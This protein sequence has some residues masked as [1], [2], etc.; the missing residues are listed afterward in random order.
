MIAFRVRRKESKSIKPFSS[1]R[2]SPDVANPAIKE[3]HDTLENWKFEDEEIRVSV[4][5]PDGLENLEIEDKRDHIVGQ[6]KL[7]FHVYNKFE[8]AQ[9]SNFGGVLAS[10]LRKM[11]RIKIQT[12]EATLE[13]TDYRCSGQLKVKEDLW[14]AG[15][16]TFL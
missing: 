9:A 4:R 2:M 15:C 3:L 16:D 14:P 11:M 6:Y 13:I 8:G 1:K 7:T 5:N 10:L 12:D